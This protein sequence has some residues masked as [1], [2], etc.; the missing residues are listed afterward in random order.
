MRNNV[1]INLSKII[2]LSSIDSILNND[3][4]LKSKIYIAFSMGKSSADF[5]LSDYDKLKKM[6]SNINF[7]LYRGVYHEEVKK[8]DL[9]NLS[10]GDKFNFNR[11]TSFSNIQQ[12]SESFAVSER[13][14]ILLK[15]NK[16]NNIFCYVDALEYCIR[17]PVIEMFK[18]GRNPENDLNW[19]KSNI[20]NNESKIKEKLDEQEYFIWENSIFKVSNIINN[21][22]G[23]YGNF[24][25]IEG[26]IND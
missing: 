13:T 25:L 21:Y 1:L 9:K 11:L 24:L 5:N 22:S 16:S 6:N 4:D 7:P 17:N 18:L 20:S 10:I 15:S 3:P 26:N 14:N 19:F 2:N 8:Y 12:K 23:K